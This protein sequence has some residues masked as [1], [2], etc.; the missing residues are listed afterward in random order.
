MKKVLL[1]ICILL[2]V[3]LF[4]HPVRADQAEFGTDVRIV[5]AF[6]QDSELYAYVNIPKEKENNSLTVD[7]LLDNTKTFKQSEPM[8]KTIKGTMP[9]S[10]LFMIDISTSMPGFKNNINTFVQ[11]FVSQSGK[12]CSFA[13]GSF[14]DKFE[15]LCD[16]THKKNKLEDALNT[17]QYDVKQTSLYT[18]L[19]NAIDY[20]DMRE[21]TE[22][23][24][25][26]IILISD[27]IEAD[28]NGITQGEV[29]EKIKSSAVLV[30]T[31]GLPTK[32]TD[33]SDKKESVEALKILGAFARTSMGIHTVLNYDN[34]MEAELA[35][36]II[37][38]VNNLY[39]VRFDIKD[40][41][42]K[43][44]GSLLR[45]IFAAP[46]SDGTIFDARKTIQIR[47]TGKEG[48]QDVTVSTAPV[49]GNSDSKEGNDGL[50]KGRTSVIKGEA[51]T[52]VCLIH[53]YLSSFLVG[54]LVIII[55]IGVAMLLRKRR[56]SILKEKGVKRRSLKETQASG[57]YM[58]A[59]FIAGPGRLE[60]DEFYLQGELY[61]G[62]DKNCTIRIK[63]KDVSKKNSRIYFKD[64]VVYIED[65]NSTNGT[66][67]NNMKIFSANK[68][69]S[70]DV[71]T[72]GSISF[73]LKF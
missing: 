3:N 30:H 70:G 12:N 27:G 11:R 8:V 21:R 41:E 13:L 56:R 44:E 65:L 16:F 42:A 18:S 31:F 19:S 15:L 51:G 62:R 46:G 29:V 36:E 17:L 50:A 7:A 71:I 35:N 28:K 67:I 14:G 69:R 61:I 6:G 34:K 37:T 33:D 72:I 25:Y 43:K 40:Y 9:V 49:A 32:S 47:K 73:N 52:K 39:E 66:L 55:I 45:L 24:L 2:S 68:L 23:E 26:N 38:Y 20:L 48:S 58:K 57:V 22:G 5:Q 54:F 59:E 10:Y 53:K 1:I 60:S 63:N 4:I 64:N